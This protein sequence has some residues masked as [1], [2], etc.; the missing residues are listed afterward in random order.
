M[1]NRHVNIILFSVFIAFIVSLPIICVD[2]YLSRPNSPW[3]LTP[4]NADSLSSFYKNSYRILSDTALANYLIDTTKTTVII[5]VDGW[6]VPY[7]EFPLVHDFSI[8]SDMSPIFAI[9]KRRINVTN[10]AE[11]EEL[12]WGDTNGIF[13]YSGDSKE[14]NKKKDNLKLFYSMQ[15]CC[16]NCSDLSIVDALDSLLTEGSWNK[17]AWTTRQT[18]EGDRATLQQLL[19]KL[20]QLAKKYPDAQFIIQGTHRPTLGSPETRRKYLAPWVPAIFVNCTIKK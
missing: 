5:L 3:Q 8:F 15:K 1:N 10:I 16:A 18:R 4:F 7:K 2:R 17:I 6:G 13:L 20:A 9:H 11:Q 12:R 14:C 19:Q